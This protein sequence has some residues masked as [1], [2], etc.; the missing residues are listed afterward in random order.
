MEKKNWY[1]N[2]YENNLRENYLPFMMDTMVPY[3]EVV[4]FL[5]LGRWYEKL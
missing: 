3:M 1:G 4:E 5:N 2:I